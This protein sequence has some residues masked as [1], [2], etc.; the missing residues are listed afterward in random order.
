MEYDLENEFYPS[1]RKKSYIG[2][3]Y[4]IYRTKKRLI[5]KEEYRKLFNNSTTLYQFLL[6]NV[7]RGDMLCDIFDIK[8]KYYDKGFLACSLSLRILSK[9][10]FIS[11]RKVNEYIK[12]LAE[13]G[14]IKIEKVK[15]DKYQIQNIYTLGTWQFIEGKKSERLYLDEVFDM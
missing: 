15:L 7:V 6:A 14:V 8:R 11:R 13:A 5:M 2:N 10:C 12:D 9:K 3:E 1:P 4:E